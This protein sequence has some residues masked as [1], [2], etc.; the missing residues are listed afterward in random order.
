MFDLAWLL[1]AFPAA[2]A[3][4]NLLVGHLLSRRLI[5]WIATGA[6]IA[7]FATAVAIFFSL[8]ALPT[9]ERIVTTHL[10]N[11]ITI[12]EF[13][14]AAALLIDPLSIVMALI[15][16]GVGALIHVYSISYM[17]H[18]E[19][20]QRF[21]IY[22]NFFIFAMLILVL[23]DSFLGMFV[24]WE[25]VGLASF[26]LIGF[27]FDRTDEMYGSYADAGKKAF[28][29]NRVG[30]FGM[31]VAMIAL[32]SV[33]GSLTFLEVFEGVEHGAL[34]VAMLNFICL[35]LLLGA[36]GKSAQIPLYV[37]LPD[38]MAGPTPVSALIHAA[39]MV[40]AGI[41]M[42]VRT[43]PLWHSAAAASTVA[44]WIGVLTALLGASIALVQ[45]DLKKILAY[46]TVS[47]LGYMMLGVG[48]GAYGAAIFHLVTHAFFKAL[49][50]LA[51]GSVMH[52]MHDV[53]D[54][55]RMGGLRRKMPA[56]FMT[57][58]IGAAALAGIPPWSGF[59]SKDA[60]LAATLTS[61]VALFVV[62]L[63]A[64]LLTAFY[65]ARMVFLTFY[66]EPRDQELYDHAHESPPLMTTP[67]W[68]LAVLALTAGALNLPVLLTLER[69]LE[70]VI[71]E[72]TIGLTAE[73]IAILL[74]ILIAAFGVLL[75]YG[76]Y[77]TNEEWAARFVA[78]FQAFQR[79]AEHKW[80][81]D[82]FYRATIVNPLWALSGWFATVV[83]KTTIDGLV[84]W[85]GGINMSAGEQVRRLQNG[86][87]P[88][89]ALSILIGV[90][91]VTLY[92]VFA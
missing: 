12:G 55:R 42:I 34:T 3:L 16:T 23:S 76:R 75:A 4:I 58:L 59:F 44:A 17:E 68:V 56:T 48:V 90:V 51:A 92:F 13:E 28:L 54:I 88:T 62:G 53:L 24:G 57:F 27:W 77:V 1:L 37:W 49:L 89:Y 69:W 74:S 81:V 40:T 91:V 46:S 43:E 47:Q 5:G 64:A 72:H 18:D 29:V 11:W 45:T 35:M 36:A 60:I 32:W 73:L 33:V 7:S 78:P 22:L 84:N 30:D 31:I 38:A 8:F 65:S 9:G 6:V 83:D 67:L 61:N 41:Y 39:T 63:V 80:Y 14:V 19:R 20:F 25:G 70:P 15:V 85:V 2:G 50:F 52:A 82:E 26:L 86:A 79:G 66:G 10:W 21:F 87:V 71:G